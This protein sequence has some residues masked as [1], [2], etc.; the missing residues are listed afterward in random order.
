MTTIIGMFAPFLAQWLYSLYHKGMLN[1]D[2]CHAT[3]YP[4]IQVAN[5]FCFLLQLRQPVRIHWS[6]WQIVKYEG[7]QCVSIF[8]RLHLALCFGCLI[9][10]TVR[11]TDNRVQQ[12]LNLLCDIMKMGNGAI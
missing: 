4:V 12:S 7:V 3:V 8:H 10:V 6:A 11:R 5:Y 9:L 2:I 1:N